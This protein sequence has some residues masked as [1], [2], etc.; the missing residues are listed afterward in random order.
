MKTYRVITKK[1]QKVNV[2]E[3]DPK[4][5]EGRFWEQ[6]N[7]P[8]ASICNINISFEKLSCPTTSPA[9]NGHHDNNKA[10]RQ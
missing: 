6:L 1:L 2:F 9:R 10:Y 8:F 4:I 3:G 7:A 5:G